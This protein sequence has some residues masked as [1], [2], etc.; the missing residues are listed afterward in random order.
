MTIRSHNMRRIIAFI[1]IMAIIVTLVPYRAFA[2]GTKPTD[3]YGVD[4]EWYNFRNNQENNGVTEASTPINDATASEKWSQKYGS[5]WSAAPTPPLILDDKLYVGVANKILEIDKQTGEKLRESD[6]MYGNVGYAMNP[7]LYADGKLFVQVGNGVVQAVDKESLKC[8]WHTEKI[9][10]QTLSPIA[11]TQ[12]DGKGYIYTGTYGNGEQSDGT[13]FCVSTDNEGLEPDTGSNLNGGG[14]IKSD[15]WDFTPSED[16]PGLKDAQNAKRGFYWA[17][18]YACENYIAVGTDD[19]SPEGDYTANA[20]FYT[21]DPTT[22]QIIDRID[23]IKGDIRTTVVYDNGHLYFSTKGGTLYK[24]DVDSEGNLTNESYIDLGGMTTA[25]PLVYKN[26]IYIGVA[27]KGGQFD[28]DGGHSFKVVDNSGILNENSLLYELPIPGYPQAAALLSNA[29]E[30]EDF[31]KDGKADGRVYLYFTYNAKPGGIYYT[32]DT[33]DA[34]DAL[35]MGKELFVPEGDKQQYCI[36]TICSDDDGTLYYKNDSCY[37]MAVE[38]NPAMINNIEL[39]ADDSTSISWDRAFDPKSKE[40]KVNTKSGTKSLSVRLTL[41]D[42]VTAEVNGQKYTENMK[43]DISG[44]NNVLKFTARFGEYT[45]TYTVTVAQT[46]DN[47]DLSVFK[48]SNSNIYGSGLYTMDPQFSKEIKDYTVD[49]RNEPKESF[50]RV[51]LAAENSGASITAESVEN[52]ERINEVEVNNSSFSGIRFNV[53]PEDANK[54]I[55]IK[56]KV[57]AQEG[58]NNTEYTLNLLRFVNVSGIEFDKKELKLDVT[59]DPVKLTP[60]FTPSNATDQSVEWYVKDTQDADSESVTVDRDGNVKPVKKGSATVKAVSNDGNKTALCNVSVSDLAADVFEKVENLGSITLE[61]KAEI[62]LIKADYDALNDRQKARADEMGYQV[63]I[64]EAE[65]RYNELKEQADKEEIDKAA[66]KAVTAKIEAIGN[67]ITLDSL[68]IITAARTAYDA[69]TGDQKALV[70]EEVLKKLKDAETKIAELQLADLKEKAVSQLKA[71]K[72]PDKYRTAQQAEIADIIANAQSQIDKASDNDAVYEI[73]SDTKTKLD[74][75][76]TDEQLT[77]EENTV[78]AIKETVNL[79]NAIGKVSFSQESKDA[80]KAARKAYDALDSEAKS[81]VENASALEKA[82]KTYDEIVA[83]A[84]V[85]RRSDDKT[86]VSV[87]TKFM[88]GTLLEVNK[89]GKDDVDRI[90]ELFAAENAKVEK[91]LKAVDIHIKGGYEGNIGLT[92]E[93]GNEYN[94]RNIAIK[95]LTDDGNVE[96]YTITVKDGKVS[97]NVTSLSP[98]VLALLEDTG[99]TAGSSGN[100][101]TD[102]GILNTDSIAADKSIATGDEQNLTDPLILMILSFAVMAVIIADRKKHK[103]I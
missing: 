92:F 79:I 43:V 48:V 18:A 63:K 13:F 52:V 55:K 19:G 85:E 70:S 6:E 22:G 58:E 80:I 17:G 12:V 103:K 50:Y 49:L 36:S 54:D 97:I 94:G 10:G 91:Y 21:L 100:D 8:L 98:F 1:T 16:D 37:L 14:K 93:V 33:P 78:K 31:D 44:D 11:Y 30:N 67:N 61:S 75:V 20:V 42:E 9:G 82:E 3:G 69:L 29:Y 45:R 38:T 4:M 66:A 57:N 71:Y 51:W 56:I 39:T 7:I 72:D 40:Y 2:F 25:A 77:K 81:L 83:K 96:T 74:A 47:A 53:Y 87:S 68:D 95:H 88:E 64:K 34:E 5:G 26:K 99:A 35:D 41:P 90:K 73:I 86:G 32:Y 23:N 84:P 27:G 28:P 102:I 65:D 15:V 101:K 60:V 62:D 59:D 89:A 24:V 46:L 76:K